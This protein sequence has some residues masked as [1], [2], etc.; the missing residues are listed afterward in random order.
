MMCLYRFILFFASKTDN[1]EKNLS[2]WL[3]IFLLSSYVLKNVAQR[4]KIDLTAIRKK[5]LQ[6]SRSHLIN[7]LYLT[8]TP[9]EVPEG[10]FF[11]SVSNQLLVWLVF[12]YLLVYSTLLHLPSLGL[13]F[14]RRWCRQGCW[15]QCCWARN[16]TNGTI[17][18]C[19]NGTR[20]GS[21]S[22]TGFWIRI[23]HRM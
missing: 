1:I 22:E 6:Y 20:T 10:N 16:G 18:F 4:E 8:E 9:C 21:G 15:S 17:T 14:V 7:I 13:Y 5:H 11:F 3:W 12:M 2:I 19:L 23:Q